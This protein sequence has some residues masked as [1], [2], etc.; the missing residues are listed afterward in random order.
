M[1]TELAA[2]PARPNP[3]TPPGPKLPQLTARDEDTELRETF[4]EF[5]GKVFFGQLLKAMRKLTDKPAYFHGGRAEEVFQ[6][7]LDEL[8][9]KKL[10]ESSSERLA[11]PM[12]ELFV[13]AR[14]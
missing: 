3:A 12:Y 14:K 7:R 11:E 9:A 13:L 1:Q 2:V 5:V 10:S 6:R 4:Q 8:L